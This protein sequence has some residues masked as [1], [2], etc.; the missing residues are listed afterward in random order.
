MI[1][2]EGRSFHL[3]VYSGAGSGC[4][5]GKMMNDESSRRNHRMYWHRQ[6][7]ENR[8]WLS[9]FFFASH[10]VYLRPSV[11]LPKAFATNPKEIDQMRKMLL[12]TTSWWFLA[13]FVV[14]VSLCAKFIFQTC[15]NCLL[16]INVL[17]RR[18][19]DASL[20]WCHRMSWYIND[21]E[22]GVASTLGLVSFKLREKCN[23]WSAINS[24]L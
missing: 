21:S 10:M 18:I 20:S 5:L 13:V 15:F 16:P 2:S 17:R 23:K 24:K 4:F 9:A 7:R 19:V 8:L 11:T 14:Q 22:P 1:S 6:T 12:L 3:W